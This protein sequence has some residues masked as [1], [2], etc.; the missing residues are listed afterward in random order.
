MT[1]QPL[2]SCW[3]RISGDRLQ[4]ILCLS[5]GQLLETLLT[6]TGGLRANRKLFRV[7]SRLRG[8]GTLSGVFQSEVVVHRVAE[9]LLAAQITLRC[10]NG[11]VSKQKLNLLKFSAGQMA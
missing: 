9:F 5:S 6:I 7:R 8:R 4:I 10:L 11:R 1:S 2:N 3:W